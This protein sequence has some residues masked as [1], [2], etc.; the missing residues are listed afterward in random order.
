[1]N[2]EITVTRRVVIASALLT[3]LLLVGCGGQPASAGPP[4][5]A[6]GRD[7]CARCGMIIS[8]QRFA[9]ALTSD[10]AEAV[11]FDDAGE[12]LMTVAEDGVGTWRAWAQDR[13]DGGWFDAKTSVFARGDAQLTPMGTGIVAFGTREA[14]DTFVAEH[15]GTVLSWDDALASLG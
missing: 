8:D 7:T 2:A 1:M 6:F 11:L 4:E 15:G 10:A 14:A 12:M 9:A 13:N 5:I 3:P